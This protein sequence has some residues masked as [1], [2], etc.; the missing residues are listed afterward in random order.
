MAVATIADNFDRATNLHPHLTDFAHEIRIRTTGFIT[1]LEYLYM[2][3][4]MKKY[5]IMHQS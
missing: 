4:V 5:L 1:S 3:N 2:P